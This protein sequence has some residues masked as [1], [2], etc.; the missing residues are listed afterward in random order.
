L[1]QAG[2]TWALGVPRGKRKSASEAG[3]IVT[4]IPRDAIPAIDRP[5]FVAADRAR[6]RPNEPVIGVVIGGEARAYSAW[7]LNRHEIVN[8]QIGKQKFA[9]VW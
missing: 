5:T 3:K 9:I 1:L 7:L 2:G 6:L 8:D 4:V